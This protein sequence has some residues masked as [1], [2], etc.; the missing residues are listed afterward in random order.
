MLVWIGDAGVVTAGSGSQAGRAEA[1]AGVDFFV[2][3]AGPDRGWA[4]W[5]AWHLREAGYTVGLDAWDWAAGDNFVIL[6]HAAVDAADRVVALLSAVYFTDGR[7][8]GDEWSAALIKDDGGRHRLVPVQIERCALPRMWRPLLRVELF[9]VDEQEA[10]RRLLAAVRGPRCPDGA[11]LFPGRGTAGA[12]TGRGESGPR[13]PG[14]LPAVWNVGPRNP[15][16][17]GRDAALAAV[18]E[19]LRAA[20]TTV[21]QALHGMGGVGKTQLAIEYAH[22]YADA[23]DLV[24]WVD[25]E[26]TSLLGEQYAALAG[27]LG[28]VGPRAD[29]TSA[30]TGTPP[31]PT[32]AGRSGRAV[33]DLLLRV[34]THHPPRPR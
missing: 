20:S 28:L 26:T 34:G 27:E 13:L 9:D 14:V 25:A 16:F 15:G 12:L 32:P 21:V 8:T 31:G 5:V 17:V 23:Y 3:H 1:A 4:E 10:V 22:R 19:R 18:R 6:M 11:P 2:S 24:W 7:Y 29:T 33:T 30:V